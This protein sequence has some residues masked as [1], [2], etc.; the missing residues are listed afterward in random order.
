MLYGLKRLCAI[1][2]SVNLDTHLWCVSVIGGAVLLCISFFAEPSPGRL[3]ALADD[4]K[5]LAEKKVIEYSSVLGGLSKI[6]SLEEDEVVELAQV[7]PDHIDTFIGGEPSAATEVFDADFG[8]EMDTE[9]D[10]VATSD[11][12]VDVTNVYSPEAIDALERLVQ[13]EAATEDTDGKTLVA[14]VVLNRVDTGIW[15]NDILSVIEAPGQFGPV[16]NGAYKVVDVDSDTKDA[17]IAAL[18]EDDI[19]H[20]AIYFQKSTAKV[21]GDKQYLFRHGSHSFYK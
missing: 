20:G 21:W 3:V 7:I 4:A 6:E 12:M 11:A 2:R 5:N 10:P 9:A 14:S 13:C 19:S 15:G 16:D 8:L 1:I 17:V 18:I